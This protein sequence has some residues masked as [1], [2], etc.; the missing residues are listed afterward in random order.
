M[1]QKEWSKVYGGK[2]DDYGWGVTESFD[3]GFVITGETFSFGSGQNDIY[4]I[5]IDSSGNKI[6]DNFLVV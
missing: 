4:V 1:D 6:W 5:K 3:K 2:K